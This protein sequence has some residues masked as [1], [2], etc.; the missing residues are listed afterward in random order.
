[1]SITQTC[2]AYRQYKLPF[3]RTA[4]FPPHRV[5][6]PRSAVAPTR[7]LRL[8][9]VTAPESIPVTGSPPRFSRGPLPPAQPS[10]KP[11]RRWRSPR[12]V[13]VGLSSLVEQPPLGWRPAPRLHQS[14]GL[15]CFRIQV[16]EDLLDDVW[17]LDTGHSKKCQFRPSP[18]I[19]VTIDGMSIRRRLR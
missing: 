11:R 10:P 8:G 17:V 3:R 18:T 1:M 9:G 13:I 19:S 15:G 2:F 5:S 14:V 4:L 12:D 16:R 7:P 6:A